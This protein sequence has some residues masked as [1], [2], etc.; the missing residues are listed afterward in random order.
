MFNDD[1]SIKVA[2]F[3][4]YM[5]YYE[6]NVV[7]MSTMFGAEWYNDDGTESVVNSD[8]AWQDMANWQKEL[9][10][11]YGYDNLQ[12]FVAGQGD[13]WGDRAGLPDRPGRDDD[14]R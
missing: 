12:R 9:I 7:T 4:P 3:V 13:E 1:G 2:G 14:R 5:A 8:P 11:F 6:T 10:D